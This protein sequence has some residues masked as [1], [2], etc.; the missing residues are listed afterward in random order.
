MN[1]TRP[2]KRVLGFIL[3]YHRV[4]PSQGE[5][6]PHGL[7]VTPQNFRD[8]LNQIATA[9][10]VLSLGEFVDELQEGDNPAQPAVVITF[11][12]GYVDTYIYAYPILHELSLPATMF[13]PTNYIQG[14]ADLFWWERWLEMITQTKTAILDW[15]EG[16]S[17]ARFDLNLQIGR[18]KAFWTINQW[19]ASVPTERRERKLEELGRI[20]GGNVTSTSIALTW[21]QVRAMAA[22]GISFGS[23]SRSHPPF[24][25]LTDEEAYAE[26]EGSKK[27]IEGQ[28]RRTIDA[29]AYPYGGPDE[30]RPEQGA[31]L[32]QAGFRSACTSLL[33]PV[34]HGCD[35]FLLNRVI[36]KD[37]PGESLLKSLEAHLDG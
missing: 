18:D 26:A 16:S 5:P 9:F 4:K 15:E 36:V 14:H 32:R 2:K 1:T 34:R 30:F 21:D 28:L 31:I 22:G 29:F 37:E 24:S 6:D 20:L 33:G 13:L 25:V 3:M 7:R 35:P 19:L 10:R 27:E 17:A 23:H 12:D 8:Q 11:D